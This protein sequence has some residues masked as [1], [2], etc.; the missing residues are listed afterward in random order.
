MFGRATRGAT[1]E[2][3]RHRNAIPIRRTNESIPG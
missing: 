1:V 3:A 2:R